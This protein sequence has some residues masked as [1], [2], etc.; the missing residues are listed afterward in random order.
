MNRPETQGR[1][2]Q[3]PRRN[4]GR[5]RVSAG[6]ARRCRLSLNLTPDERELLELRARLAQQSPNRLARLLALY[7][8]LPLVAVPTVNYSCFAN[9]HRIGTLLNQA[10]RAIHSGSLPGDFDALLRELLS[11]L[12]ET[13]KSLVTPPHPTDE[14][15]S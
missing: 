12:K 3:L 1:R 15:A 2:P 4:G 14:A 5:P 9:L 10:L 8:Q 11:E 6:L 7:G 13:R